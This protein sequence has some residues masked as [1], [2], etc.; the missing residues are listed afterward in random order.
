[1]SYVQGFMLAVP[2][3]N[4][5]AYREM[6][7]KGWSMFKRYG[8][9]SMQENWASDV[10]DGKVTSFPKAVKLEEG[11]AVVFSWIVWPDQKTYHAAWE[12]MMQDPEMEGMEM[13][14]DGMRM[15]WGGFEV[16]FSS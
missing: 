13:P 9:L 4:K 11:E 14:F 15:M 8:A 6:A 16:L 1:M 10:Q 2:E 5:D 7:E 12:K 3:A